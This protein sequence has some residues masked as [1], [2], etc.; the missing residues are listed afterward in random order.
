[1]VIRTRRASAIAAADLT[2]VELQN[3][4]FMSA[5]HAARRAVLWALVL[6]AVVAVVTGLVLTRVVP[7]EEVDWGEISRHAWKSLVEDIRD[8][9]FFIAAVLFGLAQW[10]YVKRAQ[11]LERVVLTDTGIRY[12][13]ALPKALQFLLPEWSARWN[14]ITRAYFRKK[15]AVQGPGSIELVLVT[16]RGEECRL[17]PYLWVDAADS[18]PESPWRALHKIQSM[19]APDLRRV[20]LDSPAVR[21]VAAHLPRFDTESSWDKVPL[22][23]AL[24]TNRR[25]LAAVALFGVLTAYGLADFVINEETYAARP[26][27]SFFTLLGV[28]VALIAGRWLRGGNVPYAERVGLALVLGATFGAA[29]YPGLLRIN[30]LTDRVGLQTYLYQLQRDG[31]LAP[32]QTGPPDLKFPRFA[33]YWSSFSVG[34]LHEFRLRQGGLG[35]YQVDMS[36][37]NEAMREYFGNQS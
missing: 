1:M 27:F 8:L 2:R 18:E 22:L 28:I 15:K 10:V 32:L 30:Q 3:R 35:F 31:S 12:Q 16:Y 21:F 33:D 24:E 26:P 7:I 17:R 34:S 19:K 14:E 9:V 36:P 29:L 20:I 4:F 25:A 6:F 13:S 23:Y 37:I 5:P 11:R